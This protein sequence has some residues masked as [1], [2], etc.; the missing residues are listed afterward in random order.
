MPNLFNM[1]TGFTLYYFKINFKF[2]LDFA[3]M[4]VAITF[5]PKKSNLP[6]NKYKKVRKF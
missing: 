4:Y 6:K 3:N 1:D 2:C 5:I